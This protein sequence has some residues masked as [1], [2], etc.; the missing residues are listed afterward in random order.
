MREIGKMTRNM[1]K[2]AK[3]ILLI[4]MFILEILIIT[5]KQEKENSNIV[6]IST[7]EIS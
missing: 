3:K 5:L 2:G 4:N 1:G 6:E 7:K